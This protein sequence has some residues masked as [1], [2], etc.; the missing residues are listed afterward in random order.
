M[1]EIDSYGEAN[2]DLAQV[3]EL[4]KPLIL[5]KAKEQLDIYNTTTTNP[6]V[7]V[8]ILKIFKLIVDLNFNTIFKI[9]KGIQVFEV[10]PW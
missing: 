3:E 6:L 5:A 4:K 10:A 1:K 9:P 7:M 2:Q 8:C